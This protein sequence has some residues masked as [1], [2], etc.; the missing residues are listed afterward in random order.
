M[1][2]II[3]RKTIRIKAENEQDAAFIEDTMGFKNYGDKM[4][5]E[6]SD[7]KGS[8]LYPVLEVVPIRQAS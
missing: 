2:F 8:S 4:Y 1:K 7:P 3:D 6:R 5:L